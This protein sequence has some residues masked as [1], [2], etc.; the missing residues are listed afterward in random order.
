MNGHKS[1]EFVPILQA[2]EK[3]KERMEK[4]NEMCS[5][6]SKEV[7]MLVNSFETYRVFIKENAN[8]NRKN[9]TSLFLILETF[10]TK[11]RAN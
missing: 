7:R 11:G 5:T 8:K 1:H 9:I 6:T 3:E 4:V 2:S 10:Y